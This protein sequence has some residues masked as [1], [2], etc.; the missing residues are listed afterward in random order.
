MEIY[1]DALIIFHAVSAKI[2]NTTEIQLNKLRARFSRIELENVHYFSTPI[3]VTLTDGIKINNKGLVCV[4]FE[5]DAFSTLVRGELRN[6]NPLP[7][8]WA[9]DGVENN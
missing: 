5:F 6:S 2:A 1:F 9:R 3:S 8:R 7:G 4:H